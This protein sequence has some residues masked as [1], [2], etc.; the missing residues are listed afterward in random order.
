MIQKIKDF[1]FKNTSDK[2][3]A[4]KNTIWLSVGEMGTRII[5]LILFI[6]AARILSVSEWGAFSY[7]FALIGV[8]AVFSDIGLNSILIREVARKS[9]KIPTLISSGFFL[10]IGLSLISSICLILFTLITGKDSVK[11]LAVVL[12]LLLFIDSIKEFGFSLNRATEK[13]EKEAIIKIVS[14]SILIL[15]SGLALHY[16]PTARSLTTGYIFGSAIGS[17]LLFISI[18]KLLTHISFSIKKEDMLSLLKE[19]LPLGI[20]AIFSTITISTDTIILGF[21]KDITEVG[22]YT[23]AQKPFQVLLVLPYLISVATLPILSRVAQT[24]AKRFTLLLKKI[25]SISAVVVAIPAV[26]FIVFAPII[27]TQLFGTTYTTA[28][29]LLQIIAFSAVAIIPS[30]FFSNA[31][32]AKG[33]QKLLIT[34]FIGSSI[35]NLSLSFILIPLYGM[36]GAAIT[37][38][39]TQML[40]SIYCINKIR[41][42]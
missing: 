38:T 22:Y 36:Y 5:K 39:A 3:I 4:I 10:K 9:E 31:L 12:A 16:S 24:D 40:T 28:I 15:A 2:Q 7:A 32:I 17:T 13:M 37:Y 27:I 34:F 8:F 23:A 14:A 42:I 25:T 6:Y 11:E 41:R 33:K 20:V 18:K 19:S 21:F 1:L 26:I 35:I 30:V 29:P